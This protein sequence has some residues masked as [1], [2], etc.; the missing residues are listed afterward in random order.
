MAKLKA[1]FQ[2]FESGRIRLDKEREVGFRY[3]IADDEDDLY[4]RRS[5]R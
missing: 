2:A 4:L 5:Y 1:G 3:R